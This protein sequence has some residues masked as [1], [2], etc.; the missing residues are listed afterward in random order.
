MGK[1]SSFPT[2]WLNTSKNKNGGANKK[3]NNPNI[4]KKMPSWTP[5]NKSVTPTEKPQKEEIPP[6]A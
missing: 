6:H 3:G 1:S 5:P 2:P 4:A